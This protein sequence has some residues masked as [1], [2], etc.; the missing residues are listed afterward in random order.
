MVVGIVLAITLGG[1]D[2]REYRLVF[3]NASQIVKGG[4]V[5]I[6]GVQVGTVQSISLTRNDLAEVRI[7]VDSAYGPLRDGSTATIRISGLGSVAGRYVDVSPAPSYRKPLADD[8][9]IPVDRTTSTVDVDALLNA[10]D[11][12]TRK[13]LQRMVGGFASWYAGREKQANA[14]AQALPAA[15]GGLRRLSQEITGQSAEFQQ[16]LVQSGRATS[17]L[18]REPE[19]L[20]S[21]VGGAR[22]TMEALST[23][24]A[25]LSG[26]LRDLPTA[27]QEGSE[28]LA[29]LRASIP[30]LRGLLRAADRSS[31]DLAPFL[32]QL[33]GTTERAVPV[34]TRLRQLVDR[35]G[36]GND[37]LDALR[38][39]PP[40]A[41]QASAAF[42][43]SS[44]ALKDSTPIFSFIRPYIPDL[45]AWLRGYGSA[46]ATYD[47]RGHYLRSLPLFDAYRVVDG[48]DGPRLEPK[49]LDER[50]RSDAVTNGN[51]RRCP[52]TAAAT[53]DG[54]APFVDDGPL[55]NPDCAP[56]QRIG[57]G[58]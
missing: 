57:G 8:A 17:A 35:P 52:G 47:A 19:R 38:D 42:P 51:L 9:V 39:L 56:A 50:G 54:S 45:V 29:E 12:R 10:L 53:P 40:L 15:L 20:T 23:E 33:R 30:D 7:S 16:F 5:R 3:D 6:G 26:V 21:L 13:G 46:A 58:G 34:V 25:G 11:G 2:S 44:R 24:T 14:S 41:A 48:P 31:G 43:R 49:P 28:G 22:R 4:A 32:R 37:G 36:V 55:A 18:A 1:S 27:L